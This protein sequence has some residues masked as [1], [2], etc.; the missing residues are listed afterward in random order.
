MATQ[1]GVETDTA[2]WTGQG[3]E[4]PH[5]R[6][7]VVWRG[8]RVTKPKESTNQI[9]RGKLAEKIKMAAFTHQYPPIL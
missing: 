8:E 1:A 9:S 5:A 6:S 7:F 3:Q 4:N 2:K